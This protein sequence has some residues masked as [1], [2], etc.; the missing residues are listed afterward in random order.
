MSFDSDGNY[1]GKKGV[2][3]DFETMGKHL[4]ALE[5]A[6]RKNGMFI[7]KVILKIDL[8]DN[9]FESEAGKKIKKKNI[10]FAQSLPKM[11]DNQHD[12]HYHVDFGFL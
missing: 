9:F 4:L 12:E 10:Y 11:V 7:K 2:K 6:A 1:N 3:I 5:E 8:K